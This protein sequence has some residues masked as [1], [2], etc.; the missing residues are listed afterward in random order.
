MDWI[1]AQFEKFGKR[2]HNLSLRKALVAYI[3]ICIIIVVILYSV[4]MSACEHFEN[5]IWSQY[6]DIDEEGRQDLIV[7]TYDYSKL[8][9]SEA[10]MAKLIELLKSWSIFLYSI[11]GI[12]AVSF[13]FYNKKLK[14]PL[15]ILKEATSKVGDSNLDIELYYDSKDEMGELCHSF[16]LMRKQLI[17]NNQKMWDMM[18]EQKRLNA[19]FAHDLRT[20]L[21]VLRGYTD[22]LSEYYPQGKISEDKLLSTL[23]L[24]S[25]HIERLERYSNTMKEIYSFE[26]IP[27]HQ[28]KMAIEVISNK[29][30]EVVEVLSGKNGI[31]VKLTNT[32][33]DYSDT[34]FLDEAILMEV[35]DN[36]MSNA[37][38]YAKEEIT[39]ML[40]ITKEDKLCMLSVADDGKGF[41]AK[42]LT[43]AARPYYTDSTGDKSNHF[44]IGLY[45]C[46]LLCEK[47]GGWLSIANGMQHGAIVTAVF[48]MGELD[49]RG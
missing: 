12:L 6:S 19:A 40:T 7:Y 39:V 23:S 37:L 47:H 32:L 38:R 35:F 24:M 30:K 33:E 31:S 9:K 45:I 48:Y 2:L 1:D 5:M 43:M 44:G 41:S 22:F 21:T 10:V 4:T 17:T 13:L 28:A 49:K 15:G 42:D 8:A 34:V 25:N 16:D 27:V 3:T 14:Q 11:G 26:E 46:K 18:E 36:L 29:I 20:P